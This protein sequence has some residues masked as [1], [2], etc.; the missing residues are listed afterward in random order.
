M[1][2]R[3]PTLAFTTVFGL[4][5]L[6]MAHVRGAGSNHPGGRGPDVG[7]GEACDS[8]TQ[9]LVGSGVYDITGPAAEVGMM[10]YANPSQV[11][12]GIH[13]RLRSRAFVIESPCNDKR[14]VFVSADLQSMSHAIKQAVLQRLRGLD[15]AYSDSNVL[16]SATHTHSGPG[17]FSHH[18]LYQFPYFRF[19]RQN[20]NV[21]VDGI[22]ESIKRAHKGLTPG[23][24]LV[25]TD[26][27]LQASINRSPRPYRENNDTLPEHHIDTL[28]TVLKLVDMTGRPVGMISWF[29]AHAT[30]MSNSNHLISGDNK[31]YASYSFEKSMET[32]Y[33]S[34]TTFVAA[35]AQ[36]NE[37]DATPNICSNDIPGRSEAGPPGVDCNG[38]THGEGTDDFESTRLSGKRQFDQARVLFE[39]ATESLTGGVDFRHAYVQ[40]DNVQLPDS[41]GHPCRTCKAAIG[42]ALGAGTPDGRGPL[43]A[44]R[45]G[46]TCEQFPGV[47]RFD[48]RDRDPWDCQGVKPGV[49]VNRVTPNVLPTQILKIGD[50]AI[51]AVPFEFT[52]IAGRRLRET[53]GSV[54]EPAGV[55]QVV[56]AGLANDYASYVVTPEE[57]DLQFYEGASTL[58]GRWTLDALRQEF[59]TLAAALRDGTQL[60][61]GPRPPGLTLEEMEHQVGLIE[62]DSAIYY[63]HGEVFKGPEVTLGRGV[64]DET[65]SG[66]NF[67]DVVDQKNANSSYRPGDTV[68]V[69]FWGGNPNNNLRIQSTFLKVQRAT[70]ASWETAA[71]DWDWETKFEWTRPCPSRR[72]RN[73]SHVTI[74]WGIPTIAQPGTY[75]ISHFGDWQGSDG[76]IHPYE[77][78]S[79]EFSV[80][81]N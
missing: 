7:T 51:I 5:V 11:T 57:Y 61:P 52:T 29:A 8:N 20:F 22:F 46:L 15:R 74:V 71:N 31:G 62:D 49:P 38:R 36:G 23:R 24:I 16:I 28:M 1:T 27:L 41:A 59:K 13:T 68:R 53:V 63:A 34:E 81:A 37:G 55:R 56:I 39:N 32:R 6:S 48:C 70:G 12:A 9:F 45:E 26:G 65:P 69:T 66:I 60:G 47:D 58:F 64:R 75:R 17:G 2:R 44:A 30:S 78:R 54:L 33:D 21:I 42:V 72:C 67:G 50:Y 73:H 10:G 4:A 80:L 19:N 43:N 25:A 77:G 3:V 79:R 40:M 35:F 76:R 18:R 14:V